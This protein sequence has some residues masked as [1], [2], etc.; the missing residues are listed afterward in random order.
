MGKGEIRIISSGEGRAGWGSGVSPWPCPSLP[1]L[2]PAPSPRVAPLQNCYSDI[3][4]KR[5]NMLLYRN[6]SYSEELYERNKAQW[7]KGVF[8]EW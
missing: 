1:D 3:K 6:W 8:P 4:A 5:D 7:G 2:H